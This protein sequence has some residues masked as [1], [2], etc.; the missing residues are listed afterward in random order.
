L[1]NAGDLTLD[2]MSVSDIQKTVGVPVVVGDYDLKET[3]KRL[4]DALSE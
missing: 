3:L 2:D 1:T 4:K